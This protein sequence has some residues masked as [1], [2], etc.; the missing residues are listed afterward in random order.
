[1]RILSIND[2]PNRSLPCVGC[3]FVSRYTDVQ[4]MKPGN[5]YHPTKP[6]VTRICSEVSL[7]IGA[8]GEEDKWIHMKM[9]KKKRKRRRRSKRRWRSI[10]RMRSSMS[11]RMKKRGRS[12]RGRR[13]KRR[14]GEEEE[15]RREV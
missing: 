7:L 5:I 4:I 14:R 15:E 6:K 8:G 12:R 2:M 10:R 13:S 9:E 1:M 11:S 3:T